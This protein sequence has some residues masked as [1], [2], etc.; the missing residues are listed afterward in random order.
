MPAPDNKP[1][2]DP[3]FLAAV[4]RAFTSLET[5]LRSSG[6][7]LFD[8]AWQWMTRLSGTK[9]PADYF[10]KF[11]SAPILILG[12]WL[13]QA[14]GKIPDPGL[15]T[16]LIY[17]TINKYYFIRL[18]DDVVDGHGADPPLLHAM[19][20]WHAQFQGAYFRHFPPD[21][22]FWEYFYRTWNRSAAV[23]A[24][25]AALKHI[26][27][28]AFLEFAAAKSCAATLPMAAVC[29]HYGRLEVL[30]AWTGF[31]EAFG[32]W[33]QMLDDLF[34]WEKD[35]K[36]GLPSY[37]LCEGELRK[38]EGE[39]VVDWFIREGFSWAVGLLGEWSAD[40]KEAAKA[41]NNPV[42]EDYVGVRI[43]DVDAQIRERA[44]ALE[45]LAALARLEL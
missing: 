14:L 31:W 37:L 39:S 29:H 42:V 2:S 10:L 24:Q 1:F 7:F 36:A 32:R 19:G 25:D 3:Q 38:A 18:L 4:E 23:T 5:E 41:L 17:A 33:N 28:A 43:A 15:Q 30:P 20:L 9:Y 26:D 40:M 44:A 16:D 21:H 27:R 12:W 35:W 11:R 22:G 13:E 8:R 34:D 45:T 6:D